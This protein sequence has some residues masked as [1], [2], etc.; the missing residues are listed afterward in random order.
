MSKQVAKGTAIKTPMDFKQFNQMIESIER[1]EGI[2]RTSTTI[3]QNGMTPG[4]RDFLTAQGNT[5]NLIDTISREI[6]S[7]L[8]SIDNIKSGASCY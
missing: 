1:E 7:I 3:T 6:D 4:V 8:S 2:P 5:P